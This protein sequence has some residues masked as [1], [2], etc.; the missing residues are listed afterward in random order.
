MPQRKPL[1][2]VG[3][4]TPEMLTYDERQL[5]MKENITNQAI[6]KRRQQEVSGETNNFANL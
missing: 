4:I 5:V 1:P 3:N 2:V 6:E